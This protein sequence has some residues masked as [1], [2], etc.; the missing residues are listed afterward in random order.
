MREINRQSERQSTHPISV[1]T[2]TGLH[3]KAVAEGDGVLQM[4]L[5]LKRTPESFMPEHRES[6]NG[7][8]RLPDVPAHQILRFD[9]RKLHAA[10]DDRRQANGM[11][12]SQVAQELGVGASGL[13]H[14]AKGGR[15]AFP[16]V[17]RMVR[18]LNR[19]ATEF[20]RASDW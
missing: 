19:S 13:T 15:T 1:S 9:T 11:T 3:S 16:H 12:W 7:H 5:W 10:L 8:E 20:T 2:A 18:W 14:L 4:L 17:M 6:A